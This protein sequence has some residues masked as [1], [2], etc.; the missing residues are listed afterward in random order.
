MRGSCPWW[1]IKSVFAWS[2]GS[3]DGVVLYTNKNL[4]W[5]SS[6]QMTRSAMSVVAI[7]FAMVAS[8]A[9]SAPPCHGVSVTFDEEFD[10][11]A[12]SPTGSQRWMTRFPYGGTAQRTLTAQ[13]DEYYS[14][15]SVGVDP[16]R[17]RDG[18][19]DITAALGPNRG[20]KPYT[21]GLITTYR[22]FKQLY[23]YFEMRAKLPTGPGLWPAFW[24]LPADNS[25]PP[26]IDIFEVLGKDPTTLFVSVHTR[27]TGRHTSITTPVHTADL[28]Q[29]FHV[30]AVDWEPDTVTWYL[31]DHEVAQ[32]PTP[33]DMHKPMYLLVNLAVGAKDSWPGPPDDRTKFPVHMLIDWIRVYASPDPAS[34]WGTGR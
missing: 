2:I 31:D 34:E 18:L 11:F 29:D 15:A 17:L 8:A 23:G 13:E 25:W 3:H 24:L 9:H 19:L 21:S 30:Y 12:W 7:L 16:F 28:S 27:E 26:E 22:S 32:M 10:T 14:D 6:A 4:D 5:L 1:S 20:G 33:G